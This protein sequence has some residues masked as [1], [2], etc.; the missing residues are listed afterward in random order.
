M[1]QLF[2][3]FSRLLFTY[4]ISNWKTAFSAI[5]ILGCVGLRLFE[6]ITSEALTM[7]LATLTTYGFIVSKDASR[8]DQ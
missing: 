2:I 8:K 6:Y 4:F 1:I 7:A 5:L 3:N